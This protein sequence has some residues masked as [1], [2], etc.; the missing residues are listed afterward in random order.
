M[1]I[2]QWKRAY[3]Y[4]REKKEQ[5]STNGR[6]LGLTVSIIKALFGNTA[7]ISPRK[8]ILLENKANSSL[9]SGD[10][11]ILTLPIIQL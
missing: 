3:F 1:K 2:P 10:V 11:E 9:Q 6:K 7:H 4:S 5:N 8:A